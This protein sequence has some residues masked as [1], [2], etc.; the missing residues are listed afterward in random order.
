M[1]DIKILFAEDDESLGFVVDDHLQ[2]EGYQVMR[3]TDGEEAWEIFS[4]DKFDICLLD[5]MMPK[6]DGLSLAQRIREKDEF[7]P[8]IFLTAKNQELD[9]LKG[10]EIGG[11]DY[12]TK[13]FSV[14]E[15]VYRIKVSLRRQN[16]S[17]LEPTETTESIGAYQ[18]DFKN[19]KLV[20]FDNEI[21]LTEMEGKLLKMLLKDKGQLVRR[22]DILVA[23][24]GENDYFK[25]RSL[26]VFLSRLRKYLRQ[27]DRISIKNHHGVGF[28]LLIN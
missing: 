20:G 5:I 22:E 1:S 18:L 28:S 17:I 6:L 8:I 13:P 24:W 4:R 27:D 15:L 14:K 10:F 7:V 23:I 16:K 3:A 26:D 9:R 2:M 25:G 19:L 12:V 11:D 21:I